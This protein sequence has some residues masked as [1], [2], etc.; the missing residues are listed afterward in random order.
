MRKLLALLLCL[1]LTISQ[2]LAQKQTISGKVTD[3]KGIPLAAVTVTALTGDR[4]VTTTGVTDLNGSF[5]LTINEKT[6]TLQ[7]SYIGLEEQLFT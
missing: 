4:K 1:C 6:R 2:L 3:E 7:F 5:T